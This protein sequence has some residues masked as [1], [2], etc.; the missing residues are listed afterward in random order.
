MISHRFPSDMAQQLGNS[1]SLRE[2]I[3][4]G[5]ADVDTG[6]HHR[7]ELDHKNVWPCCLQEKSISEGPFVSRATQDWRGLDKGKLGCVEYKGKHTAVRVPSEGVYHRALVWQRR[8]SRACMVLNMAWS[9]R[10][11]HVQIY[12]DCGF[13]ST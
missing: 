3:D 6:N 5:G 4:E 1:V 7:G 11:R 12:L 10:G 2:F 9:Y 13:K 8:D